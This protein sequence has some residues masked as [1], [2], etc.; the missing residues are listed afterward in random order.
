MHSRIWHRSGRPILKDLNLQRNVAIKQRDNRGS[1][2]ALFLNSLL[3]QHFSFEVFKDIHLVAGG[4]QHQLHA[5]VLPYHVGPPSVASDQ[6]TLNPQAG[7]AV[8]IAPF[9]H[10]MNY[11]CKTSEIINCATQSMLNIND[12]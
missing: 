7:A 6:V 12:F 10:V 11:K 9:L 4:V 8:T 3:F 5:L 2:A 1:A